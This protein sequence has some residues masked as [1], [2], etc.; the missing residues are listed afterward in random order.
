MNDRPLI[1]AAHETEL[2]LFQNDYQ[3]L[4]VGVGPVEATHGLTKFLENHDKPKQM[5]AVGT[6]GIIDTESFKIGDVIQVSEVRSDSH[7]NGFYTPDIQTSGITLSQLKSIK[8]AHLYAP[9]EITSSDEERMK[10]LGS[11]HQVEH[12]ESLAFAYVARQYEIPLHIILGLANITHK[13]AHEEWVQ[14]QNMC[15]ENL[16]KTL[17]KTLSQ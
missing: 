2:A 5:I 6:A 14:N 4:A 15:L 7:A 13:K 3:T 12:L 10:L 11:G 1:I 17:E 8:P 9:Q 16:F